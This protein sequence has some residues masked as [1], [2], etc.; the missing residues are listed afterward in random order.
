MLRRHL[1]PSRTTV[2]RRGLLRSRALREWGLLLW[3]D[4]R[5]TLLQPGSAL[6]RPNADP[7]AARRLLFI[8]PKLLRTWVLPRGR[9]VLLRKGLLPSR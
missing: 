9:R 3:Y 4:L 2:L 1:L 7:V 5:L 8:Q 6:L